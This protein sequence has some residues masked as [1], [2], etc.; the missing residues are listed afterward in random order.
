MINSLVHPIVH[1]FPSQISVL[2]SMGTKD[3]ELGY[4]VSLGPACSHDT[5]LITFHQ[6]SLMYERV[7]LFGE[8]LVFIMLPD[9]HMF[10]GFLRATNEE[11]T[12]LLLQFGN[13]VIDELFFEPCIKPIT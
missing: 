1:G 10:N 2:I 12:L 5:F 6:G 3:C 4:Q 8:A 13:L 11:G 9:G 7:K